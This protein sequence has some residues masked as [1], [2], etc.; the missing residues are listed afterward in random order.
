MRIV[1]IVLSLAVASQAAFDSSTVASIQ[2]EFDDFS[3]TNSDRGIKLVL[4]NTKSGDQQV[5]QAGNA[6]KG[7]PV[8]DKTIYRMGGMTKVMTGMLTAIAFEEGV[9]LP[10]EPISKYISEFRDMKVVESRGGQTTMVPV[11]REFTFRDC[12][13]MKCGFSYSYWGMGTLRDA[14]SITPVDGLLPDLA[15]DKCAGA[16][17]TARDGK[18]VR[19]DEWVRCRAKYP[20]IAQPGTRPFY[21][22]DYDVIGIALA[23]AYK[24]DAEMLMKE[25]IWSKLGMESAFMSWLPTGT[26][27]KGEVADLY[28]KAPPASAYAAGQSPAGMTPGMMYW[29]KDV[30]NWDSE[31]WNL[32][33]TFEYETSSDA[34]YP[35]VSGYGE[36]AMMTF[37]D[38][39]KFLMAVVDGGVGANGEQV[40]CKT[41]W[42]R[43]L[44]TTIE[45]D[46]GMG[47]V[48]PFQYFGADGDYSMQSEWRYVTFH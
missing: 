36:G 33:N 40:I 47:F 32:M 22:Y 37:E 4:G 7:V 10:D 14:A 39:A 44:S 28:F 43:F 31:M 5:F 30:S 42:K 16:M 38:F 46:E 18:L 20:L 23:R 8:S 25:K 12:L 1:A 35:G 21:G 6:A 41:M 19:A 24:M 13:A 2:S 45:E 11:K 27:P 48:P 3:K 17:T 15:A 34:T 26:S 9:V 29:A